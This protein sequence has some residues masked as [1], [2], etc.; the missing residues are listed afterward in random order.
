MAQL[1]RP[2]QIALGAVLLFALV[3]FVALNGHGSSST[4]T[5]GTPA[6]TP[7]PVA[8]EKVVASSKIYHGA[9]PGV[10]GLT[11]DINRAHRAVAKTQGQ[12]QKIAGSAGETKGQGKGAS[13]SATVVTKHGAAGSS[14]TVVTKH[15]AAS[16]SKTV[17][18]TKHGA[19]A[20]STTVVTKHAVHT[21][22]PK[23]AASRGIPPRQAAVESELKQGKMVLVLFWNPKGADDVAVRKEVQAVARKLG[24]KIAVQDALA[25]Q[26][27]AFGSITK[28]I[29]VNQTPT[30]LFVNDKGLTTTMTG[31]TDAFAIEQTIDEARQES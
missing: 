20:T 24:G 31:F 15:G 30:I 23:Q 14:K 18:V 7:A 6:P 1:S 11:R 9:A 2:Y 12:E 3:W 21:P 28:A 13:S 8:Q 25:D 26:V 27:G 29:Q 5:A 19:A 4:P 16:S 22:A 10:E 17:V